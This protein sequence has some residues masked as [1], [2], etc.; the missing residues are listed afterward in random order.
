MRKSYS[1]IA[2]GLSLELVD[3]RLGS[4]DI[5]PDFLGYLLIMLGLS[6]LR[7]NGRYFS[8]AWGAAGIQLVMS[9]LQ[10]LGL[11]MGISLTRYETPSL[12]VLMLTSI[13]IA[14]DLVMI[15]GICGGIRA[16]A[17]ERRKL[18]LA[19]SA[20]GGWRVLFAFGALMLF[21]LPFQLNFTKE[22]GISYAIFL[23]LGYFVASLWVILLV[24]RAGRELPGGG[25]GGGNPDDN[26][27][28]TID[29]TA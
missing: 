18:E 7:S 15:F 4:F 8:I 26:L 20:R 5:L 11:Q 29:V 3:F 1:R 25:N 16:N 13:V 12:S 17:L 19:H 27:V 9:L 23:S 14:I 21:L 6:G 22:E 2:W 24:R 28:G 10:L